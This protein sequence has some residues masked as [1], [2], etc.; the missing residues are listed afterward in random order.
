MAR[1][2]TRPKNNGAEGHL[3]LNSPDFFVLAALATGERHGYGIVK[4]I[5]ARTRGKVRMRPGN[6]YRVIDRLMERGL[7]EA[8][9]VKETG[10]ASGRRRTYRITTLGRRVVKA[11]VESVAD[12]AGAFGDFSAAPGTG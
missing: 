6:L 3:P 11:H 10:S 8:G 7:V 9:S 5:E 4:D 1:S 12:M 2:T